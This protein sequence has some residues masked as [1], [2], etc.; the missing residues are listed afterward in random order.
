MD[1]GLQQFRGHQWE[2]GK[3]NVKPESKTNL[4]MRLLNVR[5]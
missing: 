5:L 4:D 1:W 3:A 2:L